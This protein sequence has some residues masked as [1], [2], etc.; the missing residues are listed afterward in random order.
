MV[1]DISKRED[2]IQV[3]RELLPEYRR[4]LVNENLLSI[5][6]YK[7]LIRFGSISN[8]NNSNYQDIIQNAKEQVNTSYGE[9]GIKRDDYLQQLHYL[10]ELERRFELDKT[11]GETKEPETKKKWGR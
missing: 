1:K 2:P 6:N 11:I 5:D 9:K 4:G 8:I 7:K 10:R 3:A